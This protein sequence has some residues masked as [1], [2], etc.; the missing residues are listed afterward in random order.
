MPVTIQRLGEILQKDVFTD[1]GYYAG[2]VVD[3][4]LDLTKCKI[5]SV[6]IETVP[7]SLLAKMIGGK[8][9]GIIVPYGMVQSIGDVVI[10]KH[11]TS[12]PAEEVKS[13][14]KEAHQG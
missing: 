1:K 2:K 14:E 4:E 6:T 3:L 9:K 10:I 11:I 13:G 7:G 12:L 5:K 8:K